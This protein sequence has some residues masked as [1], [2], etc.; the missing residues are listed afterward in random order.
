[1]RDVS[2]CVRPS[3]SGGWVAQLRPFAAPAIP[4]ACESANA[5]RKAVQ[6]LNRHPI[7][8]N[9]D[10]PHTHRDTIAGA[11]LGSR[12]ARA[13]H[14]DRG[15]W[16]APRAQRDEPPRSALELLTA[17]SSPT[18]GTAMWSSPSPSDSTPYDH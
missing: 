5:I 2:C 3:M 9:N 12:R 11:K 18:E 1:M 17:A 14:A 13:C 16:P 4:F 8:A 7:A 6:T 10:Q 15:W